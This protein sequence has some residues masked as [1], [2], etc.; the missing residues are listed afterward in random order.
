MIPDSR[1]VEGIVK[2][3][4]KTG[5]EYDACGETHRIEIDIKQAGNHEEMF[6][7]RISKSLLR[8]PHEAII[9]LL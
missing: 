4:V 1:L 3:F 8:S 9:I 6:H 2:V 5:P 7:V